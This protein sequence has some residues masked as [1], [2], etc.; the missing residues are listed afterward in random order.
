MMQR[1]DVLEIYSSDGE[2]VILEI[3]VRLIPSCNLTP[4]IVSHMRLPAGGTIDSVGID[5]LG[6]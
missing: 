2:A 1:V 3:V 6:L 5:V 4:Q